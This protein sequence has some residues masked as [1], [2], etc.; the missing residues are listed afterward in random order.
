MNRLARFRGYGILIAAGVIF[1]ISVFFSVD[2]MLKEQVEVS[3]GER[4]N[5]IWATTQAE[6]EFY[7]FLDSLAKLAHEEPG[8]TPEET[9]RR[10]EILL[11]KVGVLREGAFA[12]SLRAVQG[13]ESM[14]GPVWDTLEKIEPSMNFLRRGDKAAIAKIQAQI[15]PLTRP[16]HQLSNQAMAVDVMV[17]DSRRSRIKEVYVEL[18]FYFIGILVSGSILVI[19]LFRGVRR[20]QRLLEERERTEER[21]RESEQRFRDFASSASDWLWDTDDRLRFTYFSKGYLERVGVNAVSILGKTFEE[22]AV[23]EPDDQ[24]WMEFR[25]LLARHQPFREFRLQLRTTGSAP[26]HIKVSGVPIFDKDGNLVSYRGTGTD[27]T[28]QVD[29]E[30]EAN[31]VRALLGDAVESLAEGFILFDPD[32]RLVLTNTRCRN[33]FSDIAHLFEPGT[34]FEDI[35]RGAVESGAVTVPAGTDAE[36]YIRA[37]LE[38]HRNPKGSLEQQLAGGVWIQVNDQVL[39]NGW[40]VGTRV[41]ITEI[42][43]REEAFRRE[44]LIWE[45]MYDGVMITD[46]SGTITNWNP[47]AQ[48]MFGYTA[49]EMLGRTPDFLSSK[50]SAQGLSI[51]ILEGVGH[52][53][54]WNGEMHFVRK[55]GSEG[56]SQTVV[57]PLRNEANQPIAAIWVN[58]DVTERKRSEEA[59]RAAKE[60]AESANIAKSRFLATMSHEIRTPMNGVLGMLELLL[61]TKLAEEQRNYVDTAR[62]SGEGLLV[63]IDDILD[64]SK[65]EAGKLALE[66]VDFDLREVTEN[67]LDLLALR[68]QAKG[69]ELS[70]FIDPAVPKRLRGDPGRL[71]QVILNLV[72]NAIKFTDRGGVGLTVTSKA[73]EAGRASVRYEIADTGVGIPVERQTEMFSEFTQADPSTTRKYGGTGLGLA[74]SKKLAELMHGEIGFSSVANKGSTFW[75]TAEFDR[76]PGVEQPEQEGWD[77]RIGHLR[78][79]VIDDN[80]TA[81]RILA[82]RLAVRGLAVDWVQDEDIAMTALRNAASKGEPFDVAIVDKTLPGMGGEALCRNI[83]ASGDVGRP[84]LVLTTPMSHRE[85]TERILTAGVDIHIQKPIRQRTLIDTFLAITGHGP[86]VRQPELPSLSDKLAPEASVALS[87]QVAEPVRARLLLAEDSK[88]NQVVAI[89]MLSKL[90]YQIDAVENGREALEAVQARAYDLVLMDVSMPEMDGLDATRAIRALPGDVSRV[91][92]IAMTAHAMESD[93]EKC[94]QSGMNDYVPKPVNRQKLLDTVARWLGE[95]SDV[96]P[97]RASATPAPRPPEAPKLAKPVERPPAAKPAPLSKAVTASGSVLDDSV[98]RQLQADTNLEIM[99]DLIR[100]YIAESAERLK[101]MATA[102]AQGDITTLGREAH[103]LK[104]SS[105]TFGAIKLQEQA[106]ALEMAC[107]AGDATKALELAKPIQAMALEASKALAARIGVPKQAAARRPA[108]N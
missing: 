104:S 82:R 25:S 79:L 78:V 64:F 35:I 67:V 86:V 61:D 12:Q 11:G 4:E 81:G 46:L 70:A 74:I 6:I 108:P 92:I 33:M 69:I 5:I 56:I 85:S 32:D 41:D 97:A 9:V 87:V 48:A 44:A 51:E 107:R 66:S 63:I 21:L 65:M 29:A 76:Q 84:K 80:E 43:R 89:A 71:R 50:D 59:L 14:I 98:L 30:R 45:Q 72:G 68:A 91:P 88:I 42:K 105:G 102:A 36:A 77:A 22:I 28:E 96:K 57:V 83:R 100:T 52:A 60:Q 2:K 27:I 101:R 3:K 26:R 13:A 23:V 93:R 19:L 47:A 55:N 62:K 54:R 53:G 90:G 8:A 103:A 37:R 15:E 49:E 16:M 34:T 58:Q 17:A 94:L 40:R 18:V 31:R 10:Y 75:F 1:S 24:H 20:A 38:Q 73:G 7:R 106:R 99:Q 95:H 39:A